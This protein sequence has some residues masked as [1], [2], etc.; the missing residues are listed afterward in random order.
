MCKQAATRFVSD[1]HV[2]LQVLLTL[3]AAQ[4]GKLDT[5]GGADGILLVANYKRASR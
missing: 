4:F 5:H 3:S 2:V 1:D